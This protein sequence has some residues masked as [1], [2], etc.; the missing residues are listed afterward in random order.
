MQ[1]IAVLLADD[2]TIV[3]Q[4]FRALLA[5]EPDINVVGEAETGRQAVQL[6]RR[7][8]PEVVV[9]DIAMPQLNGLEASRQILKEN[10]STRILILSCY[11]DEEYVQQLTEVGAAGY[12][13][14]Q[15]AA[16]ELLKAIRETKRGKAFFSPAISNRLVAQYR[17]ALLKG[18]PVR[19][20]VDL[21]T[22][23]EAEVLQLIAEGAANKQIAADLG[24][25]IKTVE[26]HRQ[27]LMNKL[28][29]HDIAGLTRYAIAKR[30][31]EAPAAAVAGAA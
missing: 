3:R 31:I 2:H 17:E 13:V 28:N 12:L 27:Q 26:K 21:L 30:V 15:T 24:I 11:S 29:I 9:M 5:A 20:S 19:K 22:T 16:G 4:G 7:L 18:V 23:R 25:S 8:K 10:P 1:K 14:K 6:V